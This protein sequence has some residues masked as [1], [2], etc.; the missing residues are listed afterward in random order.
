MIA[1]WWGTGSK[2]GGD[3]RMIGDK[4]SRSLLQEY[5]SFIMS[6]TWVNQQQKWG[7]LIIKRAIFFGEMG[8]LIANGRTKNFWTGG[9]PLHGE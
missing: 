4:I 9:Q 3:N 8:D 5:K 2:G 1:A 6:Y 7:I